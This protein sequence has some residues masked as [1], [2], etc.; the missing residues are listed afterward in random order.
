MES[1]ISE[2]LLSAQKL[3]RFHH[4]K[5]FHIFIFF[6][7][8]AFSAQKLGRFHHTSYLQFFALV[9]FSAQNLTPKVSIEIVFIFLVFG[10]S[11]FE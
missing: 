4:I 6:A 10:G 11:E 5:Y 3:G 9:P 1:A 7:L 2:Q 8:V